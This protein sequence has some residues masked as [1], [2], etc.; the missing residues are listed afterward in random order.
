MT[1]NNFFTT[2]HDPH[3]VTRRIAML[4]ATDGPLLGVNAWGDEDPEPTDEP[5]AF[6]DGCDELATPE[7]VLTKLE[8]LAADLVLATLRSDPPATPV[9]AAAISFT[10]ANVRRDGAVLVSS[11]GPLAAHRV[12]LSATTTLS[13]RDPNKRR[14]ERY[15]RIW[16]MLASSH[17]HLRRN[18]KVTQRGLY[19]LMSSGA[20]TSSLFPDPATV[21]SALLDSV[22]LVA[23]SRRSLGVVAA[24]RGEVGGAMSIREGEDAPWRSL[25]DESRQISGDIAAIARWEFRGDFRYVLV[26]EKHSVFH[27]LFAEERVHTRLPCV[28][29]TAKG[30]PDLATRA[31]LKRLQLTHPHVPFLGLVD[32]NPS[33]V[34][35]LGTYRAGGRTSSAVLESSRYALELKWLG[36]RSADLAT[37]P[38]RIP[39]TDLDRA[40][41][42]TMLRADGA[43]LDGSGGDESTDASTERLQSARAR[44]LTAMCATGFKAEIESLCPGSCGGEGRSLSDYVVEKILRGD[45]AD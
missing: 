18:E 9:P 24:P 43:R 30:F 6:I 44:E 11:D 19:Y 17:A 10:V 13:L 28:V 40:K 8:K 23:V 7:E 35:I 39:L 33:G 32:W 25:W 20:H 41:A 3:R 29:V 27:R 16:T 15:A 42:R 31:F 4:A 21:N 12:P 2:S 37:N 26:V 36:V 34:L 38:A 1:Q 14:A 5:E 45:Y 22:S